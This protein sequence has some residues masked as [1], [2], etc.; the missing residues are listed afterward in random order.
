MTTENAEQPA[1][2]GDVRRLYRSRTDRQLAGVCG[3]VA[4]YL[5]GDSTVV[6]LVTVVIGL[7]TGVVPMLILYIV[8]AIVI[9][10]RGEGLAPEPA[11]VAA[12][13]PGQGALILGLILIA[14][15]VLGFANE[16]LRIDWDLLWPVGLIA[17]GA[18]IVFTGFGRR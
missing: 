5:G 8:A 3:G 17:F 15:G 1:P 18:L 16:L 10:E 14:I 12:G 9:P 7:L 6:R 4:E 2:Q 13:R 11:P